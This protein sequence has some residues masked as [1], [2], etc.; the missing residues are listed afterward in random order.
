MHRMNPIRLITP[1]RHGLIAMIT[2]LMVALQPAHAWEAP[3]LPSPLNDAKLADEGAAS[4]DIVLGG[5][6]FWG[7]QQ[8]FQHLKGV[9]EATSGYSGGYK[10]TAT[11]HQVSKGYTN[12]VEVVKVVY[13]PSQITLGTLLRIF[14]SVAHDPTQ[15]DGQGPDKGSQYRSVI[16]YTKAQ[17]AQI[18]RD[19]IQQL[20][21][22]R[23]FPAPIVTKVEPLDAFYPAETY[24]Q[25]YASTHPYD[26]YIMQHDAPKKKCLS[27]VFPD[28]YLKEP[29]WKESP[30]TE[31]T[32][33][34]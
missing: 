28:L 14:F 31:Q 29:I 4:E 24:H 20:K 3:D 25:N 22:S 27:K 32:D 5:G 12:H 33:S 18:A 17:Q 30:A 23:I 1:L 19:Y 11:Y 15:V 7:V 16:F 10:Q 26:P 8:V 2:L 6:C 13:D 9:K 34:E 21:E